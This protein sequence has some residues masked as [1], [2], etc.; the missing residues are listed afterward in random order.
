MKTSMTKTSSKY[1]GW[2]LEGFPKSL[3]QFNKFTGININPH[4]V[5]ILDEN[6]ESLKSKFGK[7]L[8][9]PETFKSYEAYEMGQDF[10]EGIKNRL[11]NHP[12]YGGKNVFQM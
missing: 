2:I 11:I 9:D 10:N 5:V 7:I 6:E 1:K 8:L 12:K 3:I 4:L